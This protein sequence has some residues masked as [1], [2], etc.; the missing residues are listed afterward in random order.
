M[1]QLPNIPPQAHALEKSQP[2]A[3]ETLTEPII[4][5]NPAL[6]ILTSQSAWRTTSDKEKLSAMKRQALAAGLEYALVR[7][8]Q[9]I[10]GNQASFIERKV[11][12]LSASEVEAVRDFLSSNPDFPD[13]LVHDPHALLAE[14]PHTKPEDGDGSFL[15]WIAQSI[16][17]SFV[18]I[19]ERTT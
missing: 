15:G 14:Y 2:V 7:D 13:I 4:T 6:S 16:K 17:F 19:A 5:R 10:T 18:R 8:V 9:G 11:Q 3:Q 1:N 12:F